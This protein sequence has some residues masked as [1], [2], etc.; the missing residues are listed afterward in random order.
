MAKSDPDR[1]PLAVT[2]LAVRAEFKA[3]ASADTAPEN[4]PSP[5]TV[6][7]LV[8]TEPLAVTLFVFR[9]WL[10]R[11]PDKVKS[12]AAKEPEKSP[13]PFTVNPEEVKL[14]EAMT[15]DAF[16]VPKTS[17]AEFGVLVPIPI[18]PEV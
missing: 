12:V 18:F 8:V 6:R 14:P 4:D 2:V 9:D 17:R 3:S 11:V 13:F 1:A 15:S 7:P 5:L 10:S 16:M